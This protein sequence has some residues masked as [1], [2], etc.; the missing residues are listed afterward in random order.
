VHELL[1]AW[2][3]GEPEWRAQPKVDRSEAVTLPMVPSGVSHS[4]MRVLRELMVHRYAGLTIEELAEAL[5]VSR[6]AV[7]QHLTGL[8]RD[9]LVT[10]AAYRSTGGRPSRAYAPTEAGL[11]LFPRNY[12]R[13]AESLLR[14]TRELFGEE[15]LDRLLDRMADEVA[16]EMEPRLAG[17]QGEARLRT[18]TEILNEL[19]YD[20]TMTSTGGIA[21]MNCV[22]HRLALNSRAACRFD[23]QLLK[24]L[25]ASDVRHTACMADG[26]NCC[27][28]EP[29]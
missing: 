22:F 17:K 4:R 20:A 9:G 13:M 25:I 18:V 27:R 8:E 26:G 24:A 11:E 10:V 7:H 12:A 5:A 15:G 3:F 6:N 2:P 23:G 21:A 1:A 19:G 16:T 29:A 14:H 28:F